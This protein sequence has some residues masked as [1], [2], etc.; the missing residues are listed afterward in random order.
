[1][2]NRHHRLHCC[3]NLSTGAGVPAYLLASLI[4]KTALRQDE[5]LLISTLTLF[6]VEK[7]N[8][9]RRNE[10]LEMDGERQELGLGLQMIVGT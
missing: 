3:N 10:E 2:T 7:G 1:M 6:W 9:L 5:E 8:R 4:T